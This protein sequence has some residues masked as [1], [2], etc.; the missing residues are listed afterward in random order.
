MHSK[1]AD[2]TPAELNK[3]LGVKPT[4]DE[5][6]KLKRNEQLKLL[7]R[8]KRSIENNKLLEEYKEFDARTE[9]PEC[10]DVIDTIQ[11]INKYF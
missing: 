9:W 4:I 10:K 2:K 11:V 8:N 7:K 1:F 3:F 5:E 6:Q